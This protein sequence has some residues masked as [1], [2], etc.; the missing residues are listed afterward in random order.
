[1]V[2]RI[3][4]LRRETFHTTA[5]WAFTTVLGA[6]RDPTFVQGKLITVLRY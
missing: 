5:Q 3:L 4:P 2:L 6:S 1:M